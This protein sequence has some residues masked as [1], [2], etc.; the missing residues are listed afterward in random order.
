[1]TASSPR[2]RRPKRRLRQCMGTTCL[3]SASSAISLR[4]EKV[5]RS[6]CHPACL[7]PYV[8]MPPTGAGSRHVESAK[9]VMRGLKSRLPLAPSAQTAAP[10]RAVMLAKPVS[11]P[12][13]QHRGNWVRI[14]GFHEACGKAIPDHTNRGSAGNAHAIPLSPDPACCVTLPTLQRIAAAE[15]RFGDLAVFRVLGVGWLTRLPE[16]G[17]R[18]VIE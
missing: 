11:F 4:I 18:Q 12:R 8:G 14:R 7:R 1:M 13:P 17:A 6:F 2:Q 9:N 3:P 5:P 10:C 16:A 15:S